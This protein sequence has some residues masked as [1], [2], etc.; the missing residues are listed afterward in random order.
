[1]MFLDLPCILSWEQTVAIQQSI[2]HSGSPLKCHLFHALCLLCLRCGA[3]APR[4]PLPPLRLAPCFCRDESNVLDLSGWKPKELR[5]RCSV[6][7]SVHRWDPSNQSSQ[8]RLK[9]HHF[10]S[11]QI[12]LCLIYLRVC[13]SHFTLTHQ[14]LQYSGEKFLIFSFF[15][16]EFRGINYR[17][18]GGFLSF[19]GCWLCYESG[20]WELSDSWQIHKADSWFQLNCDC[21]V[22][23]LPAFTLF[24]SDAICCLF[25]RD[26]A[27]GDYLGLSKKSRLR[28]SIPLLAPFDFWFPSATR[29]LSLVG[30]HRICPTPSYWYNKKGQRQDRD[31]F[32]S[33][34]DLNSRTL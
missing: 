16:L 32:P 12:D 21:E 29:N 9:P 26:S 8:L 1:M 2:F 5:C 30:T 6:A 10:P 13:Q 11:S 15:L 17:R 7:S 19:C 31:M 18:S 24:L 14:K 33:I 23:P 4:P 27:L 3:S 20:V 22:A 28:A 25:D 34:H